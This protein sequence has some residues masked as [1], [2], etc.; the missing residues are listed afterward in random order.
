MITRVRKYTWNDLEWK[1]YERD[2]LRATAS[3]FPAEY[4]EI[5]EGWEIDGPVRV[6]LTWNPNKKHTRLRYKPLPSSAFNLDDPLEYPCA[7]CGAGR[8]SPCVDNKPACAFRV[9]FIGGGEL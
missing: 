1:P 8:K 6:T 9:F 4:L 3:L 5:E 2:T 7:S